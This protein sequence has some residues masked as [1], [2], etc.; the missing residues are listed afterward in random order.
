LWF[1]VFFF[2]AFAV[3]SIGLGIFESYEAPENKGALVV[4]VGLTVLFIGFAY[5]SFRGIRQVE[6]APVSV[7]DDGVWPDH[8]GKAQGL[9][10]WE[11][12]SSL[13][14][15]QYGQ[16]LELFGANGVSL[17]RLE[18][19]LAGF[20]SLR[21]I[22]LEKTRRSSIDIKCPAVFKKPLSYHVFYLVFVVGFSALAY[23]VSKTNLILGLLAFVVVVLIGAFE[24]LKT[25]AAITINTR[26]IELQYPLG[27]KSFDVSEVSSIQ[28]S[29]Q[30]VKGARHPEVIIVSHS[31][32]KPIRLRQLGVDA[33]ALHDLLNRWKSER[34][35]S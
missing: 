2:A 33:S 19:Q 31:L 14:E 4:Y 24:Y 5:A 32:R 27:G 21:E 34:L 26:T 22:V 3:L 18:Y 11:D 1:G 25:V 35:F 6:N 29:D 16:R 20:E 17:I 23:Y 13:K 30:F 28:L 9:V 8:L 12:V 7:D 10:R 15:R